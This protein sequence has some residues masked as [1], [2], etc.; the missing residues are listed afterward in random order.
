[1]M[2]ERVPSLI[3]PAIKCPGELALLRSSRATA[4]TVLRCV[5]QHHGR[6]RSVFSACTVKILKDLQRIYSQYFQILC[7]R[8]GGILIEVWSSLPHSP[9]RSGI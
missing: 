4:P 5:S 6:G 9:A 7:P 1:M 8:T 3:R 2:V